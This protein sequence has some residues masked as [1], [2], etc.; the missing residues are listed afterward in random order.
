MDEKSNFKS[1]FE[2]LS[3]KN[4][5]NLQYLTVLTCL[6][7]EMRLFYHEGV[8]ATSGHQC[9]LP[10][11]LVP[12][13]WTLIRLS[14]SLVNEYAF[15]CPLNMLRIIFKPFLKSSLYDALLFLIRETIPV[16]QE[17]P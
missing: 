10:L 6:L 13:S 1:Q 3:K 16:I 4:I 7:G 17:F 8:G 11:F 15:F 12:S 14:T 9:G 5:T 2:D